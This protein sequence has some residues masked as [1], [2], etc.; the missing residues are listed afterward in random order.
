MQDAFHLGRETILGR[1]L[2]D[3]P[4]SEKFPQFPMRICINSRDLNP[5]Q[6]KRIERYFEDH[7]TFEG[8]GP[9]LVWVEDE[10]EFIL[11]GFPQGK[12]GDLEVHPFTRDGAP[13][14]MFRVH[15]NE[16]MRIAGRRPILTE[17]PVARSS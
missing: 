4:A 13:V 5:Y 16:L 15:E 12:L 11:L 10:T 8:K 9:E 7:F 3:S 14:V 17:M 6:Q 1:G 2:P